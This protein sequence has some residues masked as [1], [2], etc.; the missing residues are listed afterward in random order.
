MKF[1]TK[2]IFQGFLILTPFILTGYLFYFAFAT[3]DRFGKTLLALAF[4][5]KSIVTGGG[6][7]LTLLLFGLA[8]YSSSNWFGLSFFNWIEKL[9]KGSPLT[10]G[11]YGAIRDTWSAVF[12][13][14]KI[15]SKV[16][17]VDSPST[18]FKQI[19]FVTQEKPAFMDDN[20]EWML[21]YCPHSF[22]ISGNMLVV[23]K[24]NVRF[25]DVSTESALKM[26]MSAGIVKG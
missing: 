23:P 22:Q 26:I 9:F 14:D 10:S 4:E 11:V 5:E 15:F 18:G 16:V 13:K 6:F 25:L 17:L 3:V 8:G 2:N 1:I 20:E 7:F 21:V 19:G 24:K 12:V